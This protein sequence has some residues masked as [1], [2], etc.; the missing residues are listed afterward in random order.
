MS[1]LL[2]IWSVLTPPQRRWVLWTQALSILMAFST[3]IG[4]ASIG[5]FFSVLG[6]PQLIDRSEPLKWLFVNFGFS[7]TRSFEIALGVA[8]MA[9]V[10]IANMINIAGAFLM[11][12]LSYRISA[13]MRGKS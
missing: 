5:P 2:D 7:S 1:L 3:L 4:I 6:D 13:E 12:R 11:T 8:F 10:F 9:A